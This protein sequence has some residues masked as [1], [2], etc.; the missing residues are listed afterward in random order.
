MIPISVQSEFRPMAWAMSALNLK[1][2]QCKISACWHKV[3]CV[4]R[5]NLQA[6]ICSGLWTH[7]ASFVRVCRDSVLSHCCVCMAWLCA[8]GVGAQPTAQS[9]KVL[10]ASMI[11]TGNYPW[12]AEMLMPDQACRIWRGVLTSSFNRVQDYK[13][14]ENKIIPILLRVYRPDLPENWNNFLHCS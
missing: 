4:Q 12:K 13:K 14:Q 1:V 10:S 3:S 5:E 7:S 8:L 2:R 6:Q 11:D 9:L